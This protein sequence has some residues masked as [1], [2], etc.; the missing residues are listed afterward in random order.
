MIL[1]LDVEVLM[2]GFDDCLLLVLNCEGDGCI[3]LIV[4][5]YLWLWDCGYEGGGL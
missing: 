1:F 2:F 4:F 3:V 5:D